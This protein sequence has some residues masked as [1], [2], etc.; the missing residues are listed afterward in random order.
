MPKSLSHVVVFTD[1]LDGVLT[2]LADV[3]K[4]DA[5]VN[6][7][8]TEPADLH[9]LFGWPLEHGRAR[10]AF[11]GAGAGSLDLLEIPEALRGEVRPGMRLLAYLTRDSSGA[12]A[13]AEEAGFDVRGPFATTAATGAPM[14]LV[15]VIVGGL[16]FEL[17]QF[18]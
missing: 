4:V 15:E 14:S 8:E 10:G 18:G 7:Y 2:F 16:P 12:G 9:Q 3:A 1:D 11:V 5:P 13:A 17:V 6:R